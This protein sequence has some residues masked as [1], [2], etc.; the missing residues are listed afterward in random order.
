[1]GAIYIRRRACASA[2][3][4]PFQAPQL[5]RALSQF[6]TFM[7]V[8]DGDDDDD[9]GDAD[10]NADAGGDDNDQD[11]DHEHENGENDDDDKTV[12]L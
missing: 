7:V 12:P 2:A 10:A 6:T 4:L 3:R 1:M 9:D 8:D 11:H 5:A